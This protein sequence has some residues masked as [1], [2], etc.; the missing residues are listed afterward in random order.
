MNLNKH[1]DAVIVGAGAGG[2]IVA[3]ELASAGLSVVL[4]E[5]GRWMSW[6]DSNNDELIS[7]TTFPLDCSFGPE[8]HKNPRTI[9]NENGEWRYVWPNDWS[10]GNTAACVGGGTLSYGAMAWRFMPEDFRLK[11]TYGQVE[12]STIDDWP[13][14][15]ED[16]EP[17]YETAEYECGGS[18]GF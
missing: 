7:Q 18:G 17:F 16:L 4:F 15:Y 9:A 13:I 5:R 8:K 3:K 10:Y 1:V 6:E 12:G 11:S 14:S 2:G